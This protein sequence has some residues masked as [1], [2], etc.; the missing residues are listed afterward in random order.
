MSAVILFRRSR[1]NRNSFASVVGALVHAGLPEGFRVRLQNHT[2]TLPRNTRVVA[3]SFC[4]PD[5]D[6]VTSEVR[7]LKERDDK[8]LLVAGG[9]HASADPQGTLQ[10]GFDY[11]FVGEGEETF[12]DFVLEVAEG[13]TPDAPIWR[14]SAAF[15]LDKMLHVT[16]SHGLFPFVEISR[17]CNHSCAFCQ[18]PQ[19]FPGGMR[20]RSPDTVARGVTLVIQAGFHRIRYLTPDAFAYAGGGM[21]KGP[22]A[23]A[24]LLK[25]TERA[26]ASQQML[27]SFPSEVRPDRVG[28][29]LL[30]LVKQHC[31]NRTLVLGAQS[32]SDRVLGLMRR[33]HTVSQS[34]A[35]I[36][37][38]A[39]AGL[40]PHVDILFSF[41]GEQPGERRATL[42]LAAWC[43]EETNAR[44]HAHVY[45]PL[46]GTPAWPV[47]PEPLEP[48]V[49]SALR[50]MQYSGRLDGDWEKQAQCGKQ[51]LRWREAGKILV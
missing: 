47:P 30:R 11:V 10:A 36:I 3:Y 16:P 1:L 9:P 28:A 27:G 18:V 29:D 33:G 5:L 49:V 21:K 4:T 32:G 35:A 43:L 7:V 22:Q 39:E 26:G 15:D 17:G 40:T 12:P 44:L 50:E 20:H 41:P 46:P 48:F 37:K 6:E 45:L 2:R 13:K 23:I 24:A 51:I 31:L 14:A 8:V 38:T 42:D 25:A 19:L 34:R